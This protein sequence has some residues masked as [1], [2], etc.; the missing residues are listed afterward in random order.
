MLMPR[1]LDACTESSEF[2]STASDENVPQRH[3]CYPSE[4]HTNLRQ[5]HKYDVVA[6]EGSSKHI[7]LC[8]V[9]VVILKLLLMA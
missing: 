6:V 1:K 4:M 3:E 7:D 5:P 9:I 2:V 8:I